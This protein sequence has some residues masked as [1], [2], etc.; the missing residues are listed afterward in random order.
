M[1]SGFNSNHQFNFSHQQEP[2]PR[3]K[4]VKKVV[5]TVIGIVIGVIMLVAGLFEMTNLNTL[6]RNDRELL[7]GGTSTQG[8]VTDIKFDVNG[9]RKKEDQ[10]TMTVVYTASDGVEY[11]IEEKE[12]YRTKKEGSPSEVSNELLNKEVTVFYDPAQP[13]QAVV[14]GWEASSTIGYIGGGFF[15]FL[16]SATI[17]VSTSVL[18]TKWKSVS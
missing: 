1:E 14:E 13:G 18:R 10:K 15:I 9:R 8:V 3:G 7:S 16:G 2:L 6:A 5:N 11:S 12:P 17:A 4:K